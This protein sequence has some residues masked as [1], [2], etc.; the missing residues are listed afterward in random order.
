M[1]KPQKSKKKKNPGKAARLD[2]PKRLRTGSNLMIAAAKSMASPMHLKRLYDL[3]D[4]NLVRPEGLHDDA[5]NLYRLVMFGPTAK[6]DEYRTPKT[7]YQTLTE[8]YPPAVGSSFTAA[9]P[10][11]IAF[12]LMGDEW[13]GADTPER[14]LNA[15]AP[16]ERMLPQK[17]YAM[18]TTAQMDRHIHAQFTDCFVTAISDM[19]D[20][21]VLMAD[22]NVLSWSKNLMEIL[23]AITTEDRIEELNAR[24]RT[25][26]REAAEWARDHLDEALAQAT[27]TI[28]D[29]GMTVKTPDPRPS[30]PGTP[31]GKLDAYLSSELM[32]AAALSR[33]PPVLGMQVPKLEV[34]RKLKSHS[35]PEYEIE[36]VRYDEQPQEAPP[37]LLPMVSMTILANHK[38][39]NALVDYLA[40]R[41]NINE[42]FYA[43]YRLLTIQK[44]EMTP[45]GA[46][47]A[48][49]PL[50]TR[51]ITGSL[52]DVFHD[53]ELSGDDI[54]LDCYERRP[55]PER[56]PPP[57]PD[58]SDEDHEPTRDGVSLSEAIGTATGFVTNDRIRIRTTMFRDFLD[59]GY[60]D[61]VAGAIC[62]YIEGLRTAG[63]SHTLSALYMPDSPNRKLVVAA[64]AP[65]PVQHAPAPDIQAMQNQYESQLSNVKTRAS[66]ELDKAMAELRRSRKAAGHELA[67]AE[68]RIDELASRNAELEAMLKRSEAERRRMEETVLALTLDQPDDAPD[69]EDDAGGDLP[70][71]PVDTGKD[72]LIRFYGGTDNFMAEMSHRFPNIEFSPAWKMPNTDGIA[73][74]DLIF[75]NTW[76]LKHKMWYSL[77]KAI[78]KAGQDFILCPTKGL[79]AC[80]RLILDSYGEWKAEIDIDE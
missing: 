27:K 61:T 49:A 14:V 16:V 22:D 69:Q 11:V 12:A 4:E 63:A 24:S 8:L 1:G 21:D 39:S 20:W 23:E 35:N 59:M 37:W 60:D 65:E 28:H 73:G 19:L 64:A 50:S 74:A 78:D 62:G 34:P 55:A 6:M 57:D 36:F 71:W 52:L 66:Q 2:T 46:I 18:D 26:Y 40:A 53:E 9:S 17:F 56:T 10:G 72:C 79:N 29:M 54:L 43:A 5:A 44:S 30:P 70:K 76:G 58:A 15:I 47:L 3:D 41:H 77:R 51:F 48:M 25:I 75:I 38:N 33:Q 67:A 7:A 42:V 68:S 13:D 45:L 80:S 32:G 31:I